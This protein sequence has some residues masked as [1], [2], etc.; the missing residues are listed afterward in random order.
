[1]SAPSGARGG[2]EE[3]PPAETHDL[4]PCELGEGVLW[5]PERG[6]LFWFD[7]TR[8]RLLSQDDTGPR[9]WRF[10][11]CASAAGWVDA[12]TLLVATEAALGRFDIETGA[13]EVLHALEADDAATR[14]ND[15]RADPMGGFWIGTM[16][17]GAEA[18]AGA[19][20]RLHRGELRRL[21]DGISIPNAICFAPDGRTAYFA[22]TP[23]GHLTAQALDAEG[24]PAAEPEPLIDFR[25][26]ELNP[27]GAVTDADGNLWVAQWGAGRVAC[28]A[29]DGT[30]L[31]A[32][33]VP[34]VHASCP[35]FGGEGLRDLFVTT[36]REG[37]SEEEVA[38]A[39]ENGRV[40]VIRGAGRGR[41]EP[42]VVL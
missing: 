33:D 24:W 30:L 1:M 9:E 40:F 20:Y 18:G 26:D 37:L 21:R 27:D 34:G 28:H 31:R 4:R 16:G 8:G 25:P 3:H 17:K 2:P 11:G 10:E 42:R 22:D 39:P 14:S 35:G 5:H 36:A 32:L 19:L 15:G 29:P 41:P 6:Q 38:R 13:F 7:I 12:R 23:T